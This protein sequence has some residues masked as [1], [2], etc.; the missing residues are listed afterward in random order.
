MANELSIKW[1]NI[2]AQAYKLNA[3]NL[4]QIH[5]ELNS[6]SKPFLVA[7][8][9]S[10]KHLKVFAHTAI[11]VINQGVHK[12]FQTLT[13]IEFNA[14]NNLDTGGSL[15]AGRDYYVYVCD[16]GADKASLVVSLNST[17][18]Y[19]YN[20][21]NSR[22]IGGFHTLCVSVGTIS[23]HPLSEYVAGEILPASVWCLNHRPRS[24]PEGMVYDSGSGIWVD[25]YLSSVAGGNLVSVN[26]GVIADG[27]SAE[28]FH[29]Y[30]FAQWLAR[31][32][33]RMPTQLEFFGLS[34]GANQGTNIQG[35][36]DPNTTTGHVD[37]SGRRMISNIGC[38][39]TCGVMW[40]WGLEAGG[41]G[42]SS[43]ENAF[44]SNDTGVAGQH[45]LAPNRPFFGG[46]WLSGAGCG[47][48]GSYWEASPL[49]M[50]SDAGVRG[51]SEPM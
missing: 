24:N 49:A 36:V 51:V 30:K 7:G 5:P 1:Q 12:V 44:D 18:P 32:K 19:G 31:V 17:Y 20:A 22:K 4:H 46:N 40:Q 6:I 15:Q 35:S 37:T 28:K 2:D 8:S 10:K 13:D 9:T 39:D 34:L 23:G 27:A 29:W 47:S 45:N 43:W 50:H 16:N 25:I 21:N 14:E 33:K 26:N 38:E 41:G 48:R 3:D 11:K 42:S